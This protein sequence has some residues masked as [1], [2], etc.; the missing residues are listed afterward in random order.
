MSDDVQHP[1]QGDDPQTIL[2]R[3]GS[4]IVSPLGAVLAGPVFDQPAVLTATLRSV[5][6]CWISGAV[7]RVSAVAAPEPGEQPEG[8]CQVGS[9]GFASRPIGQ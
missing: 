4:C 9:R 6:V 1:I 5:I 7:C 3:G 2:I 8:L